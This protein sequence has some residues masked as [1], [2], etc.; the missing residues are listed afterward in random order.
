MSS[1]APEKDLLCE[2]L[3][4]YTRFHSDE[5]LTKAWTGLGTATEYKRV[6][7]KGLM[8]P[9]FDN[10]RHMVWWK[11]TPKGAEIVQKWLD[12]GITYSD[13]ESGWFDEQPDQT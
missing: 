1:P 2:A 9:V 11:L 10:P 12:K 6:A 13:I 7:D 5:E 3:R 4:R 8:E